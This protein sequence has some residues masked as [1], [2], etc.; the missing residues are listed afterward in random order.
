MGR[1]RAPLG[2]SPLPRIISP[3][4]E[5]IE[6]F[7]NGEGY[8]TWEGVEYTARRG[9]V[10]W[11]VS[12]EETIYRNHPQDPYECLMLTFPVHGAP[13]RPADKVSQW[14][15]PEEAYAFAL[16]VL[17][18]YHRDEIDHMRLGQ[19]TY[20][21]LLWEAYHAQLRRPE[22]MPRPVHIALHQLESHF[23]QPLHIE[24]LAAEAGVSAAYL[25]ALFKRHVGVSPHQYLLK[26]RLQEARHLLASSDR[27]VKDIS[28]AC[29][30]KDVVHFCRCFKGRFKVTPA[31]YRARTIVER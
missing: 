2:H 8:F 11:H 19:Y 18:E 12:G 10:L 29:G 7:I 25:H 17:R 21:R 4:R 6:F 27:Q 28:F 5:E 16:E 23:A 3:G 26:R 1:Y 22:T 14:R 24:D 30:F 31:T 13:G 20:L 9:T 15:D